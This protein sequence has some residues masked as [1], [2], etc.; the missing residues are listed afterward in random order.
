MSET[1]V[2]LTIGQLISIGDGRLACGFPEVKEGM[3]KILG[4]PYITEI[5]MLAASKFIQPRLLKEFPW[6]AH[7]PEMSDLTGLDS[8][9]RY[10]VVTRWVDQIGDMYG[11]EHKVPFMGEG[12]DQRTIFDDLSDLATLR[13]N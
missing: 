4:D 1:H 13:G 11:T 9:G 7:L 5:G 2:T 3:S 10:E 12:W 6:L 8:Q